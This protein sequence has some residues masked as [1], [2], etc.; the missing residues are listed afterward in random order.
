VQIKRSTRLILAFTAGL[1][2]ALALGA[3][4]EAQ[5]P[6]T[7]V[8]ANTAD[9]TKA[10]KITAAQVEHLLK[11]APDAYSTHLLAGKFYEE[12]GIIGQAAD[13][14]RK[15]TTC[16]GAASEAYKCL[17]QLLVKSTDVSDAAEAQRVIRAGV[18]AFPKDYSM[19]FT[20]GFVLQS[21][22]SLVEAMQMYESARKLQPNNSDIYVAM[23]DLAVEMK[24]P[25]DALP[26]I[27]KAIALG[28][29]TDLMMFE[30]AKILV[31]LGRLEEAK[32]PLATNFAQN[33]LDA[34]NDKL[35]VSVLRHQ[36][37]A[38]EALTV[39]LCVLATATGREMDRAKSATKIIISPIPK[40]DA[41]DSIAK[42]ETLLKE[43]RLKGRLHFALGDVYDHLDDRQEAINQYQAGLSF[44]PNFA[45][46]Y[47]RL[48]ED[49]EHFKKDL[50]AALKNYQKAL[51]LADD[52]F[53]MRMHVQQLKAKM[54]IH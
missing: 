36:N 48:G 35:Y 43:K 13:E 22:H 54:K 30:R 46:G 4:T 14:Y 34:K 15:A 26:Y 53:D 41:K 40:A 6:I 18:K 16:K 51:S 7:V 44:D 27:E 49:L 33:P 32:K 8:P 23:S 25:K 52:D 9:S 1:C 11:T 17:A 2:P 39:E 28:K 45:R 12:R 19:F 50:P 24:Q 20:A 3:K 5:T 21:Q 29:P 10:P 38:K 47:L 37:L 42:A 31:A